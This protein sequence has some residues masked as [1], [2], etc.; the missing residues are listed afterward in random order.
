MLDN[1]KLNFSSVS[2][3]SKTK[4]VGITINIKV[5]SVYGTA[6]NFA[7]TFLPPFQ[8]PSVAHH[9]FHH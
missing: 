8:P 5:H 2:A 6:N 4:N 9:T 3:N 7:F 1:V